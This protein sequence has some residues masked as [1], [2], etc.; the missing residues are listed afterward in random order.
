VN[1]GRDTTLKGTELKGDK[2]AVDVGRNLTIASLQD[3]QNYESKNKSG[4]VNVSI[5][6]PPICAGSTVSGTANAAGGKITNEYKSVIDQSGIY[7]GQG[8]FDVHVGEHTQL[9]GAVIASD[10]TADKNRLDTGTLGWTDIENKAKSGGSQY[11]VSVSG[12]V[13]QNEDGSLKPIANGLPTASLASVSD[14][15]SSSTHSAVADGE[16]VIR[17]KDK[18]QQDIAELSR[19]TANAHQALENNF[20]KDKIRDQLETQTQAVALGT[21]AM[22]AWR[23][24]KLNDEKAKI[25]AE[26]D[27]K[28]ELKGLSDAQINAKIESSEQ[29]KNVDKEYG[30]GSEFWRNGTA[31]TGLLAGVLGGNVSG[32]M[33]AGAAPYVAGLIKDAA[34]DNNAAR[35]ALHTLASAVLVKAQGGNS[36]AGAAGGFIA[37]AASDKLAS[38]LFNKKVGELTPE[39][40]TVISNLVTALGAAGGSVAGGGSQGIGGGANAARVEVENNSMKG[41][42]P[43][44]CK[45]ELDIIGGGGSSFGGGM[46]GGGA[47][48]GL[49]TIISEIFGGD[50]EDAE[51]KPNVAKDLTNEEKKEIGGT[52]SSSSGGWGPEDDED[53]NKL[54]STGSSGNEIK[55]TYNSIKDAPQYPQGFRASQNGTTKNV[56]NDRA[57]LEQLRKVESGK[58][59]KIY[60]DGF[61][62]SGNKVSVHYFQSQSGRVFNV[63]VKPNWSNFK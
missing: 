9:D 30:V 43:L 32:G 13:G 12:G 63:K 24:S 61:D 62:A 45:Q 37:A 49:A 50:S 10:A 44:T 2:V 42:S 14:S 60:K 48:I 27:A 53:W 28:G 15:D 26:M 57:L 3:E 20:D 58:W 23:T 33:A 59:S 47:G 4:G 41:C 31:I 6:V 19:D 38:A 17:D 5:C 39:E 40:K 18:Q 1:S 46:I 29:Y 55:H 25:R 51:S 22:D 16:I 36:A 54:Q 34:G 21:Q 11:A 52:G 35:I 56:V 8:G 7:A